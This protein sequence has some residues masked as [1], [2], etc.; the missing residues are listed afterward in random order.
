MELARAIGALS[1]GALNT[2]LVTFA[3]MGL[4]LAGGVALVLG[5][6][7]A[8]RRGRAALRAGTYAAQSVP[9]LVLVFMAMF[10]LPRI[11]IGLPPFATV[12]GCLGLV[13]A[14][15]SGEVLLGALRSVEPLQREAGL[16]LGMTERRAFWSVLLPQA[17]R[18]SV[19][20]LVN[21][22]TNVLKSS[23]FA[24][25]AGVP[26]ILKEAHALT[27]TT[28][29]GLPTYMAAALLY[30]GLYVGCNAAF[31]ALHRRTRIPGFGEE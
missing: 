30:L 25:V 7:L 22:F 19:P 18:H 1:A 4:G 28:S 11:G 12:A 2:L 24:Y 21:E 17:W 3:A 26:E 6:Q 13:A 15:N 20:G 9:A 5:H 27:A 10:G 16:A 8:G 29:R 31:R 14:A 23:P